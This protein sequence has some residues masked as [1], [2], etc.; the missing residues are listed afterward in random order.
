ME[1]LTII[2]LGVISTI[3]FKKLYRRDEDN[4]L[5]TIG[6]FGSFSI[7]LLA[8]PASFLGLMESSEIYK[9]V[10]AISGILLYGCVISFYHTLIHYL[11]Y[12]KTKRKE[13]KEP[14]SL[15]VLHDLFEMNI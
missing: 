5:Y 6:Y 15:F 14:F 11:K 4:Q 3:V 10:Y 9:T 2:I 13:K 8:A 7:P 1:T 12:R